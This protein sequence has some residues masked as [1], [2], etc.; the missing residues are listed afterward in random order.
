VP[1]QRQKL[2][3]LELQLLTRA[4]NSTGCGKITELAKTDILLRVQG[5]LSGVVSWL[6]S[7]IEK[8]SGNTAT[9]T[10]SVDF[11]A[12]V[13]GIEGRMNNIPLASA[14]WLHAA[15]Q[16]GFQ[17]EQWDLLCPWLARQQPG[18]PTGRLLIEADLIPALPAK[19]ARGPV[20][21]LV[22]DYAQLLSQERCLS[23]TTLAHRLPMVRQF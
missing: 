3:V 1:S 12:L 18:Q 9:G 4:L 13:A 15:V 22:Q 2:D 6:G 8:T 19:K 16:P 14:K 23:S 5:S 7:K 20:D 10:D 17:R 21:L 11:S